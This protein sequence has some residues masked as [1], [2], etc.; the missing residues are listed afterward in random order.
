MYTTGDNVKLNWSQ[1]RT[2]SPSHGN[3]L[4][5]LRWDG[6]NTSRKKTMPVNP[7]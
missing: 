7:G 4:K 1:T 5:Y 6:R 3:A 2:H